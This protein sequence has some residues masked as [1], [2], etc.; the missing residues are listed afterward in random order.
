MQVPSF[1]ARLGLIGLTIGAVLLALL[2]AGYGLASAA[3][4]AAGVV[5]APS[6][7]GQSAHPGV[8][9]TY[10]LQ[11]TNTGSGTDTFDVSVSGF[12]WPTNLLIS[13]TGGTAGTVLLPHNGHSTIQVEVTVPLTGTGHDVAT[14]RARSETDLNVSATATLTT[15]ALFQKYLPIIHR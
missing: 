2:V 12:H 15:T 6:T 13:G 11:I 3:P 8:T 9:V 4:A 14:V 1:R 10:T 5:V 7:A